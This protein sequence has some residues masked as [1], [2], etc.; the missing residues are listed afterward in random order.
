[1]VVNATVLIQILHFGVAYWVMKRI[2]LQD[3]FAYIQ[4]Q[5]EKF[6]KLLLNIEATHKVLQQKKE[7]ANVSLAQSWQKIDNIHPVQVDF[8]LYQLKNKP[9][10][11]IQPCQKFVVF[12]DLESTYQEVYQKLREKIGE[13]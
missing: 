4:K 5:E 3:A 12:S 10:P 11:F 6:E 1:M 13:G 2:V 7:L 8:L 9:V